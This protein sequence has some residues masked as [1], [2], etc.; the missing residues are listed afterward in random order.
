MSEGSEDY[1]DHG[2][3]AHPDKEGE[4]KEA[5][6]PED[7]PGISAPQPETPD[8]DRLKTQNVEEA[9]KL[10]VVTNGN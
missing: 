9:K 2:S 8:I 1:P 3:S 7:A 10:V 5:L 6:L 4:N